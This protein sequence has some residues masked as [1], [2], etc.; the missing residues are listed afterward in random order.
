MIS[1]FPKQSTLHF[2]LNFF[3]FIKIIA[4]ITFLLKALYSY[5]ILTLEPLV[6]FHCLLFNFFY[7]FIL[8]TWG[9]ESISGNIKGVYF[10]RNSSILTNRDV[11]FWS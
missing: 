6:N 2:F 1:N 4:K 7:R 10:Q 8:S 5:L 11:M 3:L 9:I